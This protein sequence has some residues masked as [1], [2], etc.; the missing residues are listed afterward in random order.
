ME[1]RNQVVE[2]GKEE[3]TNAY[4]VRTLY[5]VL[6]AKD[7]ILWL[8][9]F[10]LFSLILNYVISDGYAWQSG[11]SIFSSFHTILLLLTYIALGVLAVLGLFSLATDVAGALRYGKRKGAYNFVI[12]DTGIEVEGNRGITSIFL[13][14]DIEKC[15]LSYE[16]SI[17]SQ[18]VIALDSE[19]AH[20]FFEDKVAESIALNL[21]NKGVDVEYGRN[22]TG[23]K[24]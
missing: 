24:K 8:A 3:S 1:V 15:I 2:T 22:R 13:Y 10:T 23:S 4:T 21:E 7:T 12:G 20:F 19:I 18:I 14:S 6:N 17:I 11:V 5:Y 9:F 16:T